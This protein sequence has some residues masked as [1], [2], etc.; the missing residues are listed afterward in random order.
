MNNKGEKASDL[1]A[2]SEL[3]KIDLEAL[4]AP[5]RNEL[6]SVTFF[7]KP[8]SIDQIRAAAQ[9]EIPEPDC[10]IVE[11]MRCVDIRYALIQLSEGHGAPVKQ[12]ETL[13]KISESAGSLAEH[14]SSLSN[15]MFTLLSRAGSF[16]APGENR[17]KTYPVDLND[18]S[19]LHDDLMWLS[20][21]TQSLVNSSFQHFSKGDLLIFNDDPSQKRP[22]FFRNQMIRSIAKAYATHSGQSDLLLTGWDEEFLEDSRTTLHKIID[23]V[24]SDIGAKT[25]KRRRL[26]TILSG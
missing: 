25:L 6:Q 10:F 23:I 12:R 20:K 24:L 13:S 7:M 19:A 4:S 17:K 14:I 16:T 9:Q 5:M 26:S 18:Q 22:I 2:I 8:E 3:M 1:K 11:V 21:V 15:Y